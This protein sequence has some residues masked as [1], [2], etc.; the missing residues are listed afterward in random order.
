MLSLIHPTTV[1]IYTLFTGRPEK[2]YA[3]SQQGLTL[4]EVQQIQKKRERELTSNEVFQRM[5][6]CG[7]AGK[8]EALKKTIDANWLVVS[9][10][11]QNG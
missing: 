7:V 4:Q 9:C 5:I 11:D 3:W 1:A 8:L 2:Y 6:T 10:G